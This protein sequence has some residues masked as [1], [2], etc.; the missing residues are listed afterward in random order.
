LPL[1]LLSLKQKTAFVF[2]SERYGLSKYAYEQAD[3]RVTI[4]MYG[5]TQSYNV[6]VSASLCLYHATQSIKNNQYAWGLSHDEK[7]TILYAWLKRIV[8]KSDMIEKAF[9]QK[10]L[11]KLVSQI[12]HEQ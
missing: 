9:L 1:H 11:I 8:R 10:T 7:L 5:L 6:T 3:Q 12:N 2:G 4:P